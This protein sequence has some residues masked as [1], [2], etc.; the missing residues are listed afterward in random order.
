MRKLKKELEKAQ[1]AV[2]EFGNPSTDAANR[3]LRSLEEDLQAEVSQR[4]K[5]LNK[6]GE[7]VTDSLKFAYFDALARYQWVSE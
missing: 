2:D 4:E 6:A 1:A 3:Q 7:D 5:A